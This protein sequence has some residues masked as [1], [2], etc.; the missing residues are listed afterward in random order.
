MMSQE[1]SKKPLGLEK[2]FPAEL[3]S[4]ERRRVPRLNLTTEQ[5]RHS[6]NGKIYSVFDLSKNGM[7]L[8]LLDSQEV[9][10]FP[11]GSHFDGILSLKRV[12]Y[13]VRCQVK[14][15][16]R[17]LVGCEFEGMDS[18]T[19]KALDQLLDPAALG[20]ELRPLPAIE[21]SA[22]WYHAPSGTDLIIWRASDGGYSRLSIFLMGTYV[23]WEAQEG[24]TSGRIDHSQEASEVRGVVRFE[25]LVLHRD[26]QLDS[27]KLKIAKTLLIS[28]NL[29]E[30]LKTWCLKQ[31]G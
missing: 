14:H 1:N 21:G 12:K 7:G 27:S 30:E 15:L 8:R 2:N 19:R 3:S 16:G 4:D 29:P 18:E 26:E 23:Q 9:S 10:L 13:P 20:A 22:V 17:D 24:L 5:F 25:T 6:Q 11:V 31:L 28:S